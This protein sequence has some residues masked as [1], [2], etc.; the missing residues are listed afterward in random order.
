ML[1]I[2]LVPQNGDPGFGVGEN[3]VASRLRLHPEKDKNFAPLTGQFLRKYIAYSRE[4]VFPR[5]IVLF[6][7]WCKCN[8]NF[9]TLPTC[10]SPLFLRMSKEAAA[11]LKKFYLRLRNRRTSADGTPITAR[12]LESL[13]RLSE[14]R[15]RVDLREEVTAEDAQVKK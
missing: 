3:S 5:Y 4:R 8:A 14:A 9:D 6:N 11:I 7:F 1:Q 10:F 12:Q 2:F 15:A 13:V